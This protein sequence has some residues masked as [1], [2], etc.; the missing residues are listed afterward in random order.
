MRV[1]RAW[2]IE[3]A[4]PLDGGG[5]RAFVA[6]DV[7]FKRVFDVGQAL[8]LAEMLASLRE[9]MDLR[10][11]Q[12]VPAQSGAWVVEGWSAW[13]RLEGTHRLGRWRDVLEVADRFH[14]TTSGVAWSE[15]INANHAWAKADRFAWDEGGIDVPPSARPL[16][17]ELIRRRGRLQLPSQLIHGDLTDNVLFHERLAPAVIDI[18]PF[19]R[20]AR[21]AKAV[22]IADSVALSSVGVEAIQPLSDP[23]GV[24]L[25]VRA[26]L[27]RVGAAIVLCQDDS[28][29]L[30]GEI[31][32]YG[33]L[34]KLLSDR[35]AGE[36]TC[37]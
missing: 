20:P 12:P 11:I 5:G 9:R 14:A 18:S 30:A 19:W 23:E 29:R 31:R 26:T 35:D 13:H 6:N 37:L 25:L 16:V 1:L 4:K 28:A 3:Q 8:W 33:R 15:A 22:V 17:N 7:V 32:A 24:E 2:G 10:V 27:F 21:Y 34:I 36:V